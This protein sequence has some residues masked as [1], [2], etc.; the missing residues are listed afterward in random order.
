[1]RDLVIGLFCLSILSPVIALIITN[2]KGRTKKQFILRLIA[3]TVIIATIFI[4][5]SFLVFKFYM[6]PN[7]SR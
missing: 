7:P 4:G 3:T 2:R 6:F 5:L 1:M